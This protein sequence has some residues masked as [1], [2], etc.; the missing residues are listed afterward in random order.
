[1][2]LES[3]IATAKQQ[4]ASDLHLEAGL[5]PAL[6]VRGSL[7][8]MS[9]PVAARTLADWAREVIGEAQW[10]GFQERRS[11]D[12]CFKYRFRL[13]TRASRKS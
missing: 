10:P 2:N 8:T 13:T 9:E 3:L 5:P 1:M 12:L 7:R 11:A 6:R 4:G